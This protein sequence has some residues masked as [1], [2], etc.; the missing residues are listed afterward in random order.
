MN[1]NK[2]AETI[3]DP[4]KILK[5]IR[6]GGARLFYPWYDDLLKGKYLVVVVVSEGENARRHWIITAYVTRKQMEGVVEWK[7][8]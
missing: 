2:L 8:S 4:D 1:R 6:H 3:R 5:S 7:R